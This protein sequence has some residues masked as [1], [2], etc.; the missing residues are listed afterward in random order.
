M[1]PKTILGRSLT[2]FV[3]NLTDFGKQRSWRERL[4]QERH[5]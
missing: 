4:L 3:E 5:T 1:G 2:I